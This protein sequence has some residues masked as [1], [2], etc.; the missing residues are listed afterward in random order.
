[1]TDQQSCQRGPE[2]DER[3][4]LPIEKGYKRRQEPATDDPSRLT[5][6]PK[7]GKRG[8]RPYPESNPH[9]ER[10]TVRQQP[11]GFQKQ[12]VVGQP[13]ETQRLPILAGLP[14]LQVS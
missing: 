4:I 12:G 13:N 10:G 2:H 5:A 14:Q 9:R 1:M 7:S 6:G 3:G 11:E 8:Q